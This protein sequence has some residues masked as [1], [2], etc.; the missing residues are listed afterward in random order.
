[1]VI[2]TRIEPLMS[3]SMDSPDRGPI[4]IQRPYDRRNEH[5]RR[6]D[7][8]VWSVQPDVTSVLQVIEGPDNPLPELRV[9]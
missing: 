8:V 2:V 6:N 1:M 4:Y 7:G 9:L 5:A 3:A